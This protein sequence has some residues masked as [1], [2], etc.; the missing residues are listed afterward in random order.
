M[1]FIFSFKYFDFYKTIYI[2]KY[3]YIENYYYIF[4]S[5]SNKKENFFSNI[6]IFFLIINLI[7]I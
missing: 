5:L 4:I 6:T 7:H 1:T 2:N 3:K